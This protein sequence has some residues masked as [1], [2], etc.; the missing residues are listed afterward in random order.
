[1]LEIP[2]SIIRGNGWG[3]SVKDV[4]EVVH[5]AW[6]LAFKHVFDFGPRLLTRMEFR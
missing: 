2:L 3:G 4:E 5:G 6:L 1:M